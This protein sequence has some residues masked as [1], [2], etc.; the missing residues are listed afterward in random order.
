MTRKIYRTGLLSLTAAALLFVTPSI[1]SSSTG[2]AQQPQPPPPQEQ[3]MQ[4]TPAPK[5]GTRRRTRRARGR[6]GRAA[7]GIPTGVHNCIDR[8]TEIAAADPLPEYGGQAE[9]IINDGLMWN[10]EKSKCSIGS[11]ATL[12]MKVFDLST[13]WRTKDGAKVR[14]LLGEIKQ[15]APQT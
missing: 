10:D 4:P 3:Q 15:A 13:A 7:T 12:R 9:Q 14:S 1:A 8:L 11:D 2:A 5:Q 6:A